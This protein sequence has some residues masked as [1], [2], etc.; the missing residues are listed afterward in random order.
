M[1]KVNTITEKLVFSDRPS[2]Y[3][4]SSVT[5][6]E[7]RTIF[8]DYSLLISARMSTIVWL[9]TFDGWKIFS[10]ITSLMKAILRLGGPEEHV[11]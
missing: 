9:S 3:T 2:I 1:T 6:T 4:S 8:K 5:R 10:T 7:S 11:V